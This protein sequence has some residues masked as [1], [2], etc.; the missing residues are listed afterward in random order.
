MR[1]GGN[2]GKKPR[3]GGARHVVEVA[4]M[5]APNRRSGAV[6]SAREGPRELV[7]RAGRVRVLELG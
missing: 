6:S 2:L 4:A 7:E 3:G 5:V 1:S